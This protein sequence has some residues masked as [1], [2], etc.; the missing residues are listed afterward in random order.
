MACVFVTTG[1]IF[2]QFFARS[3]S[4]LL[5]GELIGGLV[6]GCYVVIAPAYASEVCPVAMRG[7][8]TAFVNL[9]FVTGQL[10]ANGVAAGT[11]N[12]DSHWA[13][14]T[15]FAIQWLWPVFIFIGLPFAPESPWWLAR[16][17]DY[18]GAEKSLRKLSSSKVDVKSTLAMIIETDR[19]ER[20]MEAGSTYWDC[21]K[22]INRRRT[23]IAC[24]VYSI[25]VLSGIYMVGYATYFF[26]R[27]F[28]DSNFTH[29]LWKLLTALKSQVLMVIK[30]SIWA[31]VIWPLGGLALSPRGSYLSELDD[32]GSITQVLPSWL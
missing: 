19:L 9:V 14:S 31:L 27:M 13:Y 6:L 32:E 21:F 18:E 3:L 17:G 12:I 28:N 25:Q 23:E 10:I 8:L 4:V 1:L 20:A 24:G 29:M 7:I 5:A 15:P 16:Q 11:H 22:K 2:V 26:Q 30:H